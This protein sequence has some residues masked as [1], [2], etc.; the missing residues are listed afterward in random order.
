MKLK[1]NNMKLKTNINFL[2][3]N[4]E[5]EEDREYPDII[6]VM[7]P[8]SEDGTPEK[9][10][11]NNKKNNGK[12]NTEALEE[13]LA[14]LKKNFNQLQKEKKTIETTLKGKKDEIRI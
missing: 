5:K 7:S 10:K 4:M 2:F 3:Q 8:P 1:N 11:N 9:V 6:Q 13:E 12:G 14:K